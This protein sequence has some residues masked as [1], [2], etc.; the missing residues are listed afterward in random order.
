MSDDE[1]LAIEQ[2]GEWINFRNFTQMLCNFQLLKDQTFSLLKGVN[3][4]KKKKRIKFTNVIFT[5]LNMRQ[6]CFFF[7]KFFI[8]C[9]IIANCPTN[10]IENC[11]KKLSVRI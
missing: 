8:N 10:F 2:S 3:S 6:K 4:R 5:N 11:N 1:Y 7:N 9:R